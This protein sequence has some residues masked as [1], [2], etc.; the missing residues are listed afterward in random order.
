MWQ[1]HGIF[2]LEVVCTVLSIYESIEE[3]LCVGRQTVPFTFLFRMTTGK[4]EVLLGVGTFNVDR[5]IIN[6][7]Q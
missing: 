3:L 2:V 5:D 6:G 4:V 7:N 1:G